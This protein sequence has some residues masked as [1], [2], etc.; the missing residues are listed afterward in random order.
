MK[1]FGAKS[2]KSKVRGVFIL[3]MGLVKVH[4]SCKNRKNALQSQTSSPL[5]PQICLQEEKA[6]CSCHSLLASIIVLLAVFENA[7]LSNPF[8]VFLQT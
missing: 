5:N 8:H 4:T 1:I 2:H 3:R 7:M 6:F